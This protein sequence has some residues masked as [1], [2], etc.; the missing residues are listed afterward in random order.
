MARDLIP[1]P[2]PAGRPGSSA[3]AERERARE[4]EEQRQ[5]QKGGLWHRSPEDEATTL[6]STSAL[7]SADPDAASGE[8]RDLAGRPQPTAPTPFR[9]RF[10]LMLGALLG[11]G[12]AALAIGAAV[13]VGSTGNGAPSGWSGWKPT[14]D[15]G[16]KAA[17]QI[18]THVGRKYRLADG[19]QLVGVQ[20]GPL[21]IDA[22]G[23]TVPLEIA[24]KTAPQGGDIDFIKGKG[25][26]YTLNG[27]G[28][29]G[30]VRGGKPSAERHLLLRREALELALYS[31]RYID[32]V[33]QVVALLP[34]APPDKPKKGATAA[35]ATEEKP[36][37]ALFFRPGD[38][39][40]QLEIPLGAT[41]PARTPRP[42][43]I[44]GPEA[45]RID[46][47][48]RGNLFLASFQ[49]GQDQKAYLVLDRLP[50]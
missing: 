42:E 27:L 26:M 9:S 47:L 37:Q 18:A 23:L 3:E 40:P 1:P 50:Q 45:Q 28:P 33:D 36:T 19:N 17:Q 43:T 5:K 21:E 11:L 10:G 41:I 13:Y 4:L 29:K 46:A 8:A 20:G 31:F 24:M 14:A 30:S 32:D 49:Q 25:L 44:P 12:I 7:V 48:T 16:E 34:P 39:E 35:A 22:L 15:D 2:S 6:D 38:L